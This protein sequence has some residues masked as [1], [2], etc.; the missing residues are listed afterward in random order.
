MTSLSYA[1]ATSGEMKPKAG[2]L[3]L[4]EGLRLH[5]L[6]FLPKIFYVVHPYARPFTRHKVHHCEASVSYGHL[7]AWDQE[8][9]RDLAT[10][11]PILPKPLQQ[12]IEHDWSPGT[13][14]SFPDPDILDL[15]MD[16][17]QNLIAMVYSIPDMNHKNET[18]Y[19]DIR[20]L[21]S[22]SIHP[23]LLDGKCL[24]QGTAK[25]KCFGSHIAFWRVLVFGNESS[26][27]YMWE[28]Q[29]S[30]WQHSMTPS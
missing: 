18:F 6:T 17:M 8:Y 10:I 7:S 4:A 29:I 30:D 13:L 2:F 15:L 28:L 26:Y 27:E 12:T 22:G 5:I 9:R 25:L 20:A 16:P 23:K 1:V 19:I 11:I 14:C 3:S 21:D 24:C